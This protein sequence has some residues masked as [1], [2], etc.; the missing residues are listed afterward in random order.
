MAKIKHGLFAGYLEYRYGG[1]KKVTLAPIFKGEARQR[2]VDSVKALMDAWRLSPFQNEAACYHGVRS[3]LCLQGNSWPASDAEAMSLVNAALKRLG[4]VRPDWADGQPHY[5][6]R[7]EQCSWCQGP[8]SDDDQER[9]L[10]F[11]S[12]E[13]AKK[14]IRLRDYEG[15]K[16]YDS[17]RKAAQRVIDLR[18]SH[19]RPCEKCSKPF[20]SEWNKA[21]FCSADCAGRIVLADRQCPVCDEVFNP[22]D[23][24]HECCSVTCAR[25]LR[26]KRYREEM[27]ERSCACCQTIFRPANSQSIYCSKRC[28]TRT[29]QRTYRAK[30]KAQSNVIY[31][32]AAV[33]DEWFKKAA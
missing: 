29:I 25:T 6:D 33:F 23:S 31:L 17:L 4:A 22:S 24:Q 18:N 15:T 30:Q 2:A 27:P 8:I 28:K 10:R 7:R 12:S 20:Q 14:A 13:C 1:A 21:R 26:V 11:C 19:F 5:A 32:T 9:R 16:I 3:A